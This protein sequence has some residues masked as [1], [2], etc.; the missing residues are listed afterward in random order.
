MYEIEDTQPLSEMTE[1]ELKSLLI[2]VRATRVP[3]GTRARKTGVRTA[4]KSR[5]DDS[6]LKEILAGTISG[7]D[8]AVKDAV[9]TYKT[10]KEGKQT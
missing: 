3:K 2:R 7:D 4:R 9:D 6:I 1:A 10:M 5:L 8:S